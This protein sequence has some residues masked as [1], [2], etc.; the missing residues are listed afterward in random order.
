MLNVS[1]H[2][3]FYTY[4]MRYTVD[5]DSDNSSICAIE[6]RIQ[7]DCNGSSENQ[8]VAIIIHHSLRPLNSWQKYVRTF[9]ELLMYKT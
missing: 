6:I 1:H 7:V 5:V 8:V 4:I 2:L 3:S 9:A